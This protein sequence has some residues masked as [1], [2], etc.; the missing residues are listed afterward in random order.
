MMAHS[1]AVATDLPAQSGSIVAAIRHHHLQATSHHDTALQHAVMAGELLL[2]QKAAVGH[3]AWLGWLDENVEF[4]A[5][6]AQRYMNAA[7][8]RPKCDSLSHSHPAKKLTGAGK[9][10]IARLDR[11]QHRDDVVSHVAY[12]VAEMPEVKDLRAD[13]LDLL[14][15]LRRRIDALLGDTSA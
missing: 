11:V 3:G 5:R 1:I 2:R 10:R 7:A 13:D 6:T 14:R 4:T 9:E 15:E 8:P 12:V